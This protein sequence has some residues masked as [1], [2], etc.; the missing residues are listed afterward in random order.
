MFT[1]ELK[2]TNIQSSFSS[3]DESGFRNLMETGNKPRWL[4]HSC[5]PPP[6]T[7]VNPL[8][9]TRCNK[10]TTEIL[11]YQAEVFSQYKLCNK[12]FIS[13]KIWERSVT[14][15]QWLV[16][17]KKTGHQLQNDSLF[18]SLFFS[19]EKLIWDNKPENSRACVSN[20]NQISLTS[21]K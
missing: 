3:Q 4:Q 19:F 17:E 7:M 14:N 15:R 13:T 1:M 10:E 16:L 9:G 11:C 5:R 8:S 20:I 6:A 18:I 2:W 12:I 21:D